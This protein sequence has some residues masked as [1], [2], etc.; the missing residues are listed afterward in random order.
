MP[1][2]SHGH[3]LPDIGKSQTGM[4]TYA[5]G[6]MYGLHPDA[7]FVVIPALALPKAAAVAYC[8][9]FVIGTVVAMGGYTLLIGGCLRYGVS[10]SARC[11]HTCCWTGN[12]LRCLVVSEISR[13]W[14]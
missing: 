12:L 3:D 14:W 10:H 6:I 4:A 9:L 8:S 7:L 5:T 11:W 13:Q 2:P 1:T